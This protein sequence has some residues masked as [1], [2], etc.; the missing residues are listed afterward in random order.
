MIKNKLKFLSKFKIYIFFYLF[1]RPSDPSG[2]INLPLDP[3]EKWANMAA[4]S[5][6]ATFPL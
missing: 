6:L 3:Y 2:L 1:T 4:I 5:R